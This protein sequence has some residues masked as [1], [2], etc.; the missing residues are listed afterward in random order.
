MPSTFRKLTRTMVRPYALR[1]LK[2][3]GGLCPL[4]TRPIDPTERMSLVL[5]HCHDT[6]R[7]RGALCRSCNAAEG[8]VANAAGRWGAKTMSYPEIIAWLENLL[9]YLKQPLRDVVYPTFQ[10]EDEKRLAT[11]AKA[12]KVRAAKRAVAAVRGKA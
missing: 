11:N 2:E 10:T 4:C 1:L 8:K 7:V 9:V 6:G 12:R 5:D 3:Q